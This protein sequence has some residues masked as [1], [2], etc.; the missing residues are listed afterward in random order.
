MGI[1][2]FAGAV[3]KI[4]INTTLLP[5]TTAKSVMTGEIIDPENSMTRNWDRLSDNFSEA[6][7][8]LK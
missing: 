7:E 3:G 2:G 4:A 6:A 8:E 5:L 1:F